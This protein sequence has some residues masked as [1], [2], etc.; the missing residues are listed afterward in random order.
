MQRKVRIPMPIIDKND[1]GSKT[2]KNRTKPNTCS[3]A[4]ISQCTNFYLGILSY[5]LSHLP[6]TC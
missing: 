6:E 2:L 5:Q 3:N 4:E 1:N